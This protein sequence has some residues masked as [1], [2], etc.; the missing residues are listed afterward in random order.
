LGAAQNFAELLAAQ[1]AGAPVRGKALLLQKNAKGFAF[2][3]GVILK[4]G[5]EVV[6]S[7]LSGGGGFSGHRALPRCPP[8]TTIFC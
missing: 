8:K 3:T 1:F 7:G 6:Y 5:R 4:A 2:E